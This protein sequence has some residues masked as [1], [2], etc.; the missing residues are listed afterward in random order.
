MELLKFIFKFYEPT[1]FLL[2]MFKFISRMIK[3]LGIKR[4]LKYLINK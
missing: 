4:D 3:V 2:I 1:F